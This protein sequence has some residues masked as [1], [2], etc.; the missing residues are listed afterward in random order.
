MKPEELVRQK[1]MKSMDRYSLDELEGYFKD[2]REKQEVALRNVRKANN[3]VGKWIEANEAV[4]EIPDE[5]LTRDDEIKLNYLAG[6]YGAVLVTGMSVSMDNESLTINFKSIGGLVCYREKKGCEE[7]FVR[8]QNIDKPDSLT[9]ELYDEFP[10]FKIIT[11]DEVKDLY[12]K[13]FDEAKAFAF[14][15][16]EILKGDAK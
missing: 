10:D 2:I 8:G 5:E 1:K 14:D 15:T 16:L 3:L 12:S 9:Y 13:M 4:R 11:F 7:M 6:L